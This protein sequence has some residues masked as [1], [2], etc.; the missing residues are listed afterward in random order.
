MATQTSN[1]N[2][3]KYDLND[4][5]AQSLAD[6]NENMDKIDE[7][8]Y[9]LKSKANLKGSFLIPSNTTNWVDSGNPKY[10]KKT[11]IAIQNLEETDTVE[12]FVN[13][14]DVF[15]WLK[16]S[17]CQTIEVTDEAVVIYTKK[18]PTRDIQATYKVVV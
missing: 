4:T 1:L 8:I 11:T 10:P 15:D 6:Q 9:G 5:T 7:E 16:Y 2:L 14:N 13:P 12:I 18:V 17:P 3:K